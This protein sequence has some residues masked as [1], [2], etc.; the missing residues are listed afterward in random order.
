M[1]CTLQNL[2]NSSAKK[3]GGKKT[4]QRQAKP[5]RSIQLG[6]TKIDISCIEN[7]N[8]LEESAEA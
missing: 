6:L 8:N 2:Q 1:G 5:R 3:N 4:K 7:G